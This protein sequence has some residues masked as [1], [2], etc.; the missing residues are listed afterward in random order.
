M[1]RAD[2]M[3]GQRIHL[4]RHGQAEHNVQFELSIPDPRLTELGRR[5]ASSLT[6]EYA[7]L[8]QCDLIVASPMRRS[9]YCQ[10][11]V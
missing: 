8:D 11:A 7:D 1:S 2:A 6:E 4:I 9:V 10:Y 3:A 5:Q